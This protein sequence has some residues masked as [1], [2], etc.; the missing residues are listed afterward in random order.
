MWI[1]LYALLLICRPWMHGMLSWPGWLTH[2]GLFTRKLVDPST[3][4]QAWVRESP[5]HKDRR[6]Y[7]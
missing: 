1:K 3:T 5:P 7:H 4:D 2:S 6:R